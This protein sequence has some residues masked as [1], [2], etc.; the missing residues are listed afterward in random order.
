MNSPQ[1][2][3]LRT[4]PRWRAARTQ[5]AGSASRPNRWGGWRK[6]HSPGVLPEGTGAARRGAKEECCQEH[7]ATS[8]P[9]AVRHTPVESQLHARQALATIW[10]TIQKLGRVAFCLHLVVLGVSLSPQVANSPQRLGLP[11]LRDWGSGAPELWLHAGGRPCDVSRTT[12]STRALQEEKARSFI[13][14]AWHS[15]TSRKSCVTFH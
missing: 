6:D 2:R 11:T 12:H 4:K 9:H 14:C 13:S 3:P 10:A 5:V 7:K 8:A 1:D 15:M